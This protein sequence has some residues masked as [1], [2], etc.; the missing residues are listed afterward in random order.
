MGEMADMLLQQIEEMMFDW[1]IDDDYWPRR[2][3]VQPLRRHPALARLEKDKEKLFGL[4]NRC[5][6]GTL[7]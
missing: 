3:A 4:R 5:P 7:R 1:E 6:Q 2:P